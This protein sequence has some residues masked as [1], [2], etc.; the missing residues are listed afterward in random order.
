M[1]NN[2]KNILPWCTHLVTSTVVNVF[3]SC[4]LDIYFKD[5]MYQP[6]KVGI[7]QR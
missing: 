5:I 2:G 1:V 7:S 3:F 4:K 6:Y